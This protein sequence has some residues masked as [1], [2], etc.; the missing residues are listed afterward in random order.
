MLALVEQFEGMLLTEMLRDVEGGDDDEEGGALGLGG[1]TMTDLMRGEFGQALGRA[2]GLGLSDLLVAAFLRQQSGARAPGNAL[3]VELAAPL[4]IPGPSAAE[5]AHTDHDVAPVSAAAVLPIDVV[6]RGSRI[7]SGFGLRADP[8]TG[9]TRFHRGL[10]LALAY[11]SEVRAFAPGVVTS[12]GER[13]GYGLTVVVDHGEGRETLY[14]HLS[15]VDV[16]SGARVEAGQPIARSGRSG[17]ATGP[18]L[19]V[20][21]RESGRPVDIGRLPAAWGGRTGDTGVGVSDE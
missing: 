5:P 13:A 16:A 17:R 10:D 2:G 3:P 18:H 11:G 20:E 21:A 9:E 1:S 4:P 6:S 8:F 14:A 12:A 19:H 7:T 15:A